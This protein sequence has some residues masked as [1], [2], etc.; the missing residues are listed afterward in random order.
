M[1]NVLDNLRIAAGR[2][3]VVC[4]GRQRGRGGEAGPLLAHS[5]HFALLRLGE[6]GCDDDETQVDH[7]KRS[8]LQE[9]L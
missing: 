4:A 6:L 3:R 2:L 9:E 7:K 1:G 5:L 8:N